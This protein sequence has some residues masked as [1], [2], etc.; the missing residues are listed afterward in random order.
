[1]SLRHLSTQPAIRKDFFDAGT[2]N[3]ARIV[4]PM[5]TGLA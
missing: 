3:D 1:V 4:R 2:S 5:G